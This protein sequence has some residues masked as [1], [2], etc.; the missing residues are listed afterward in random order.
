MPRRPRE[1]SSEKVY[2]TRL[3]QSLAD[4]IE[5][6]AQN[7]DSDAEYLVFVLEK[8]AIEN[9]Y[10]PP[11]GYKERAAHWLL[12]KLGMKNGTDNVIPLFSIF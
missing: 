2:G 4:W 9:G 5:K 6:E 7:Y 11:R 3:P 8:H 10:Q 12:E 1:P